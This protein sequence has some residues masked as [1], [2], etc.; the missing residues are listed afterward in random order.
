MSLLAC[1]YMRDMHVATNLDKKEAHNVEK[2]THL[3]SAFQ[4]RQN[5]FVI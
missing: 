1:G 4:G 3:R 2:E 5:L